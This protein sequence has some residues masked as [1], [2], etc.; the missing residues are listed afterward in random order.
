MGVRITLSYAGGFKAQAPLS[1]GRVTAW[2]VVQIKSV[3]KEIPAGNTLI[4]GL[5]RE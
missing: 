5:R 1:K 2:Y 3:G 4:E